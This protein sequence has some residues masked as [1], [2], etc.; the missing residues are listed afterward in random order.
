MN[1]NFNNLSKKHLYIGAGVLFILGIVTMLPLILPSSQPTGNGAVSPTSQSIDS[2]NTGNSVP[3][4]MSSP[5]PK[6][7]LSPEETARRFYLWY[8]V[9]KPLRTGAYQSRID[10]TEEY[11]AV[12]S[13]Y[14]RRGLS[15][16]RDDVFNCGD[17]VLPT[18]VSPQNAEYQGDLSLVT[19]QEVASGRNLF[20][21]KLQNIDTKWKVRDVWCAP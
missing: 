8:V 4:R 13:K 12:M 11:K 18:N 21:I 1:L 20:I 6:E 3:N 15:T 9:E 5:N 7:T 19:L 17:S 10:I 2:N 16:D 14:V